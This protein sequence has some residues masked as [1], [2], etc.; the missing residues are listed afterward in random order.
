MRYSMKYLYKL[1][2]SNGN[3][4]GESSNNNVMEIE[5][6]DGAK[7]KGSLQEGENYEIMISKGEFKKKPKNNNSYYK[8]YQGEF[9][10][11][12]PHGKDGVLEIKLSAWPRYHLIVSKFGSIKDCCGRKRNI[13]GAN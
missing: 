13:R 7:F 5:Y 11:G 2:M 3:L 9:V 10:D 12:V 6:P 8:R 1:Y 4:F